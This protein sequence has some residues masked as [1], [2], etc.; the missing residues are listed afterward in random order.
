MLRKIIPLVLAVLLLNMIGAGSAY[1]A[2]S[3]EEK[4]PKGWRKI[5]AASRFTFHLPKSMKLYQ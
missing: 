2:G 4:D 3:K 1:A 5:D